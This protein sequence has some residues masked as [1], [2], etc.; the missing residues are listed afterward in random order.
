MKIEAGQDPKKKE[1]V[2]MRYF[3]KNLIFYIA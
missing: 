2:K 1:R 3:K